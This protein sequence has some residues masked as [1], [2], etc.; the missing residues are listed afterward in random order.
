M[1]I[2]MKI[3]ALAGASINSV[4]VLANRDYTGAVTVP[5]NQAV[6]IASEMDKTESHAVSGWPGLSEIPG[7]NNITE[8]DVQRNYATLL[9]ILT[10]HVVRSPHE[11]GTTPMLRVEKSL[12][13]R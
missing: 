4:P 5:A 7:L 3:T 1:T 8:K 10:P 6:V 11:S 9:V 12:R 2:D 13:E